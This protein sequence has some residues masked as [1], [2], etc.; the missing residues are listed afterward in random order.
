MLFETPFKLN[1]VVSLKLVGGDEIV[2][3]LQDERTD[4]YIELLRPLLVVMAQQGFGM[5]PYVLTAGPDAK[6][7]IDRGHIIA[8]VKTIDPVSKEYMKQTSNIV[9]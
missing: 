8:C 5:I 4:T 6:V 7:S 3:R 2:G 9:I 1:D